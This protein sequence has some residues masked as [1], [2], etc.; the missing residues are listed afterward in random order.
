M[1]VWAAGALFAGIVGPLEAQALPAQFRGGPAHTGVVGTRGVERLGGVAW[2][3][4][5]GGAVRGTPTVADGVVYVGSSDGRL[6]ALD[7]ADGTVRWRYDAGTAVGGAPLVMDDRL[8][9]VS[10]GNRIHAV[11]RSD[12]APQWAVATG[13]DLPLHWGYEGWDYLL[14]SPV[15]ADGTLLVGSGDGHLYALDPADG[16]QRWRFRTGGRIR[17]APAVVDG[18]AYVGSGDGFLYAV[19]LHDGRERAHF[20]TAG[21]DLDAAE[22]GF[23]RTQIQSSPA[24]VDSTL[25]VGSRDAALYALD[26][27][28]FEARWTFEDGSAWV[29]ASP[30]VH[31]GIVYSARSSSGRVRAVDAATG[32]ERWMYQ[33]GALV[34]SSPVVVGGTV[35]VGSGDSN[36]YA[37]DAS[38]GSVRWAFPTGGMVLSTP[39]VWD[40]VVYFGSDDGN[41]YALEATEGPA[42]R[43][44]VYWDDAYRA[45]SVIG[46]QEAHAGVRD[47]FAQHGYEILDSA[48]LEPFLESGAS[49]GV[50]SVVV[51]AMDG[52]PS[53]VADPSDPAASLLR[54]YLEAGGKVVWPGRPPLLYAPD[55]GGRITADRSRPTALVGADFARWNADA[56]PVTP[57]EVGRRWGLSGGRVGISGIDPGGPLTVLALDELGKA[58]AWVRS[59][60]HGEGRGFVMV[61]PSVD[62]E[63]LEEMRHVAEF[64]IF[65]RPR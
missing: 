25:Y 44:V 64:G 5:T 8:V 55:E 51:F 18:V 2:T 40:G 7:G 45:R 27:N 37:L 62:P 4:E 33:T 9:V 52:V 3:F 10:R 41:V 35:Y 47:H 43:R 49:G 21:V 24:V 53:T 13:P 54:R 48:A 65:R 1:G 14:P 46:S 19:D 57:T 63:R 30:A 28:T 15:F 34:F 38:D 36:L 12:G 6:Y 32:R 61:P 39:A 60:G 22:F 29:V 50:A 31:D 42:P 56:Y 20:R 23:D 26:L 11:R 58:A 17:S 16:S 59:Y